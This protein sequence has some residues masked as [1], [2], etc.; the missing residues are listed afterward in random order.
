MIQIILTWDSDFETLESPFITHS[1]ITE[2]V[3]NTYLV[4]LNEADDFD[5]LE[6]EMEA[7]DDVFVTGTYNE[8]GTQYKWGNPNSN[9]H[10]NITKYK[11]HLKGNPTESEALDTQVNLIYG[12]W[13]I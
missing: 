8:D 1:I 3:D 7:I 6:Q 9:R 4:L 5:A 13:E 11:D 10:H 2:M 12:A